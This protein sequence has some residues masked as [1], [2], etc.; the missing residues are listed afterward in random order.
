MVRDA[1]MDIA[2]KLSGK[3]HSGGCFQTAISPNFKQTRFDIATSPPSALSARN[4]RSRG[5]TAAVNAIFRKL[6]TPFA[7]V[8]ITSTLSS[9]GAEIWGECLNL[10]RKRPKVPLRHS[11]R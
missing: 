4:A 5:A 8:Q 2:A 3:I 1:R 11:T 9:I 6:L 10:K 7:G